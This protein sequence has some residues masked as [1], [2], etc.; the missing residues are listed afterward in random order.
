MNILTLGN[1][2]CTRILSEKLAENSQNKIFSTLNA[3]GV[4]FVDIPV[5]CFEEII[6][7]GFNIYFGAEPHRLHL[8]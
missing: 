4:S 1:N 5:F 6:D 3:N 8:R 2:F 7:L